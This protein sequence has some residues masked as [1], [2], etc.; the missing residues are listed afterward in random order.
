MYVHTVR[1]YWASLDLARNC[2][3]TFFTNLPSSL[4]RGECS[5]SLNQ[6]IAYDASAI[7]EY[8]CFFD[9]R[10]FPRLKV[11]QR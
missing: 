6:Q 4:S 10:E 7:M 3:I 11:V 2:F 5:R 9:C 1:T 8:D